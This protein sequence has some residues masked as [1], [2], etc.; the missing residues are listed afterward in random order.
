MARRITALKVQKKN[1]NRVNVYLDGQFAFG[2]AAIEAARLRV[3]QVLS[4]EDIA[5]LRQG[6]QVERAAERALDLLS[7]RPR[8]EAELRSRLEEHYDEAALGE[9]LERLRRGGLLDDREFARYWVENRFQYNPRGKSVLR[10][11][12]RQKGL[13]DEIIEEALA[14]YDEEQAASLAAQK[15]LR[16][17]KGAAPQLLR[18]RLT[19]AL[20][21]R[22]FPYSLVGPIVN[23]ILTSGPPR[24]SLEE[25]SGL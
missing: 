8:S 6:D 21:R 19:N 7:Y 22:G 16:R 3:G 17:W 23:Q 10:Q 9:A 13:E 11:E 4:D 12:L 5:R 1:P 24:D 14:N 25:E 15:L 2:L 18:R 20:L